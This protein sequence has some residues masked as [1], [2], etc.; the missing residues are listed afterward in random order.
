MAGS[1]HTTTTADSAGEPDQVITARLH[2]RAE[3]FAALLLSLSVVMTAWA[4]FQSTKWSGEQANNYSNAGA[5]RIESTRAS[6][7]AGQLTVIDVSTFTAWV[8]ALSAERRAGSSAG[9]EPDGAYTPQLDAESGFLFE[10]FRDEFR[11]AVDAWLA[12][13]PL[14]DP[15]APRTP[16]AMP[17]YHLAAVDQA[18]ELQQQAE[19]FAAEAREANQYGDNYVLMTIVFAVVLFF[20]GVSSNIDTTRARVAL[21][22]VAAVVL[23]VA[24]VIVATFPVQF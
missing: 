19:V 17:E 10:R 13:D 20:A 6:T 12:T 16:F 1:E 18:A 9:L 3:L 11:P 23:L 7:E 14:T 24:A 8:A 21:L 2:R 4:A 5:A 22:A 15:A